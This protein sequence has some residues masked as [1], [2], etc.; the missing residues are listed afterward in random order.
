MR[1]KCAL[2]RYLTELQLRLARRH[3]IKGA[4]QT[5]VGQQV[6]VHV[7]PRVFGR[8]HRR[9]ARLAHL[10]FGLA[11]RQIFVG[12]DVLLW[13]TNNDTNLQ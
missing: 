4:N 13:H 1:K 9:H 11:G 3:V 7:R 12:G 8:A 5:Q 2:L 10:R 6:A